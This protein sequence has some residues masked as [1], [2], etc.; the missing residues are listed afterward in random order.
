M[1]P[2]LRYFTAGSFLAIIVV[3]IGV[4]LYYRS[5]IEEIVV[6]KVIE[7]SNISIANGFRTAVWPRYAK[8]LSKLPCKIDPCPDPRAFLKDLKNKA[9]VYFEE[10]PALTYNL[11]FTSGENILTGQR[12]TNQENLEADSRQAFLGAQFEQIKTAIISRYAHNQKIY[13][14]VQTFVPIFT[15]PKDRRTKAKIAGIVEVIYDISPIWDNTITVQIISTIVIL[16]LLSAFY[17][18][19]IYSVRQAETIIS[20]QHEVALDLT[21][22]KAT[23]EEESEAK[24]KFLA[25]IS[26]ELRTPLNA[27]IGFSEILKDEA[28]GKL[29]NDQYKDYVVD[30]HSSGV[31]L[32]S[33]INDILDYSK[34]E[35]GKLEIDKQEVDV[36]KIMKSSM[37]LV[38]PR[39]KEAK[40]Q[41][42]EKIPKEH[43][44]IKTDAKRLKQVLLNLLSNSVKFTPE[45]GSVTLFSWSSVSEGKLVIEVQ[46]TGVGIKAKDISKAM[47]SFGQADNQ[48]NRKFEGTGLG[49]P[50]TKKLIEIMGGTF[51]IRSQEGV[52]TTATITL[53]QFENEEEEEKQTIT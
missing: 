35:A 20:K 26:H 51:D 23:A 33:L 29:G 4:G 44:V 52:G 48:L 45:G 2:F 21:S 36:T 16:L 18:A 15:K 46:D 17:G 50:L 43:I 40:V 28:L 3:M 22:A 14:V 27:I 53:P 7:D 39:A 37:R 30:I 38:L 11:Y 6:K 32:L 24:S 42:I 25:N 47:A 8:G 49:L 41:L 34:A 10:S 31:H 1:T 5:I 13:H 12:F 9:D 19:I